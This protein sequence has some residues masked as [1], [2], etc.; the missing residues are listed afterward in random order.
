MMGK[1]AQIESNFFNSFM[2]DKQYDSILSMLKNIDMETT[3]EER[4]VSNTSNTGTSS[5]K[6]TDNL[7]DS[8]SSRQD[9]TDE[10]ASS[11]LTDGSRSDTKDITNGGSVTRET[12]Y[13]RKNTQGGSTT[14]TDNE[15]DTSKNRLVSSTTPQSN[16]SSTVAGIDADVDWSYAS[17][18]QDSKN[19]STK[20]GT[21]KIDH[22]LTDTSS[23]TDTE[24]NTDR[25]T[26]METY[27]KGEQVNK[28]NG[29]SQ[30][31]FNVGEQSVS[32]TGS[33]DTSSTNNQDSNR[34]DTMNKSSNNGGRTDN[35]AN[36]RL[37]WRELLTTTLSAYQYLFSELDSLFFSVW[38]IDLEDY[39]IQ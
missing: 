5:T 14:T 28:S 36:L 26:T 16:V 30:K 12:V 20:S 15:T 24:T 37:K 34:T 21:T 11:T 22:G 29:S 2:L 23:G 10:T 1:L 8:T 6:R 38:N 7:E 19:S 31:T 35:L 17:G 18:L 9:S 33:Q 13:G 32:H 3:D 4:L 25:R 39:I 27:D